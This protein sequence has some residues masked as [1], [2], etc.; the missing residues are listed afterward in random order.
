MLKRCLAAPLDK[1]III[2]VAVNLGIS[3][4][5]S[6]HTPVDFVANFEID[7]AIRCVKL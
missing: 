6:T 2:H 1:L 4:Q 3:H 5:N 7:P